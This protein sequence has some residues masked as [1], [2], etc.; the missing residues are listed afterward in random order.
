MQALVGQFVPLVVRS[1]DLI[2]DVTVLQVCIR[3]QLV[4]KFV[5]G[6]QIDVSV[7]FRAFVAVIFMIG[8]QHAGVVLYPKHL[9][10]VVPLVV[11]PS[12][13][14]C[15]IQRTIPIVD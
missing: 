11:V 12:S 7:G 8:F 13:A 2:A 15:G 10:E 14:K 1:F 3:I 6:F 9:S 5:V 4:G